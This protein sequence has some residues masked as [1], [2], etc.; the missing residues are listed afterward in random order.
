VLKLCSDWGN[1][2]PPTHPVCLMSKALL[3]FIAGILKNQE[4]FLLILWDLKNLFEA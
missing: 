4:E 2:F 1:Y 3:R